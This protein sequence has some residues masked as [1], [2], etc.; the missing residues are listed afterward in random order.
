[1][2]H[3]STLQTQ[4]TGA[5]IDAREERVVETE[6]QTIMRMSKEKSSSVYRMNK[7]IEHFDSTGCVLKAV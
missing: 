7:E 5:M 4:G 1:M 6:G 2:H 3:H